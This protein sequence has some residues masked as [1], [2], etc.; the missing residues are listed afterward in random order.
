MNTNMHKEMTG[1]YIQAC[2]SFSHDITGLYLKLEHIFDKYYK[3]GLAREGEDFI[4]DLGLDITVRLKFYKDATEVYVDN[5]RNDAI[6]EGLIVSREQSWKKEYTTLAEWGKLMAR[7]HVAIGKLPPESLL[8]DLL[9]MKPG[10]IFSFTEG[11]SYICQRNKQRTLTFHE[12]FD[13]D[14]RNLNLEKFCNREPIKVNYASPLG[15]QRFYQLNRKKLTHTMETDYSILDTAHLQIKGLEQDITPFRSKKVQLGPV[16]LVVKKSLTGKLRWYGS[17]GKQIDKEKV[18]YLIGVLNTQPIVTTYNRKTP[19]ELKTAED[20]E[21]RRKVEKLLDS[22]NY[23]DAYNQ[24]IMYSAQHFDDLVIN[25]DGFLRDGDNYIAGTITFR[26]GQAYKTTYENNDFK[27]ARESVL[28]SVEEF[29][30]LCQRKYTETFRRVY[31]DTMEEIRSRY[32]A[33]SERMREI[34]EKIAV[35]TTEA[36]MKKQSGIIL[37]ESELKTGTSEH[38]EVLDNISNNIDYSQFFGR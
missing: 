36:K 31:S 20:A 33:K 10:T 14:I 21:F 16:S 30:S 19:T 4:F 18:A 11:K 2:D 13:G 22:Q 37:S 6:E 8:E 12:I 7:T 5:T 26:K 38:A 24:M 15:F 27:T 17:D 29:E 35:A 34:H 32:E 1:T 9:T 3:Q 28:L 23:R 25:T